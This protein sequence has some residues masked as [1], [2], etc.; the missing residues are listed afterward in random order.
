MVGVNRDYTNNPL[1]R[2]SQLVLGSD[3]LPGINGHQNPVSDGKDHELDR[4]RRFFT[5]VREKNERERT[6]IQRLIARFA[7][8][9][10]KKFRKNSESENKDAA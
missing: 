1:F 6:P 2:S 8:L 4:L 5:E 9:K 3:N 7:R 10:P